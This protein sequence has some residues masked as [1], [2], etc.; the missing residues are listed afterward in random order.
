MAQGTGTGPRRARGGVSPALRLALGAATAAGAGAAG[1]WSYA[2]TGADGA[3][4]VRDL[5][6]GW[7]YAGAGLVAWWRRPAN[8]TGL[9]MLAEGITWFIG[10]LQGTSVPA[11]F[12]LGAWW[13]GLNL[14]I[15]VH[16]V[17]TFPDGRITGARTRRLILATYAIVAVGGLLRALTYDPA[18]AHHAATYLD[19]SG[20]GPNALLVDGATGLFEPIDLVFRGLAV[21]ISVLTATAVVHRWRRASHARRRALLPAW[22][23]I[24]A[25]M[26]FILWDI[27]LLTVP[28]LDGLGED[29]VLLLSDF[30]QCAVPIA[31]LAG[32]LR[33][34]LKQAEV[35]GLVI[36]VGA[37]PTPARMREVLARVLDD[38]S[39]RL[40]LWQQ[41]QGIRGGYADQDG[42]PVRAD[43]P[44]ATRVDSARGTP[45]AVLDHDPALAEDPELLA[46]VGA[47][48]RLALENAWLRTEA[49]EAG[50]R[51]VRAA[52][53]ERRRLERDLH[54]G[55]QARIV[56]ALMALRRVSKGVADHPDA[57]VRGSVAEVERSLRLA[58]E[59][60]R[61]LAHGIHPA[62]LTREGLAPALAELARQAELPVV[63]AAEPGRYDPVVETTAYF[64]VCETL[65]NAAK[66]ARARA[67]SVSARR[68]GTTLVVETVDDG[69]GG[70]DTARGSGLAGLADRIA[71]VDGVLR[72][73]SPAGGGTRVR[74]ELP[75]V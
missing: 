63:V 2:R 54:D 34:R 38:S 14:A 74:V 49:R 44:R 10:N 45:L 31:F 22:V 1:A 52:D 37:D 75:C 66:H 33:M 23:A 28:G 12:A 8:R 40:G 72:V 69:I 9:L 11:L 6:V 70:A 7:A 57:K 15:L 61:G 18:R 73:H 13:E 67:V 25:A 32:L 60:L 47:A 21:L 20:C 17:L 48:L 43:G 26:V 50:T 5:A 68:Q 24:G 19:C 56:F 55:A 36:E 42:T 64:T 71:A 58:L 35:G 27:V 51:M 65:A 3:D 46:A 30:A 16:L 62:V 59:E 4:I 39:L 53:D 29:L 41:G